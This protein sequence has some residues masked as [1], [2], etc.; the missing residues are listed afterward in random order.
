MTQH[1][2]TRRIATVSG[3][4][5]LLCLMGMGTALAAT[6]P[7][8]DGTLIDPSP[9]LSAT[10]TT[11]TSI[12]PSP[13]PSPTPT[14]VTST[15]TSTVSTV[16][17]T[18]TSTVQQVTSTSPTPTPT[19]VSTTLP[20]SAP[21]GSGGTATGTTTTTTRNGTGT[22]TQFGVPTVTGSSPRTARRSAT[23]TRAL[24]YTS[25][26][27]AAYLPALGTAH[28]A[29][30]DAL[31]GD[32]PTMAPQQAQLMAGQMPAVAPAPR[33]LF[34]GSGDGA[35]PRGLFI[36]VATMVIGALAAGHVKL[37][38]DRMARATA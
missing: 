10:T 34:P 16:T 2:T 35:T 11:V 15:L 20:T 21:T 24:P 25:G 18:L 17:S 7:A 12:L 36:A 6:S 1:S 27:P 29:R 38:Q 23:G 13:S 32:L 26:V 19:S 33:T 8:A 31:S 30:L 28:A 5:L 37:A 3:G 22:S 4:T 9:T 14:D